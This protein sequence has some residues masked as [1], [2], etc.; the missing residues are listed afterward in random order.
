MTKAEF[1]AATLKNPIKTFLVFPGPVAH[2]GER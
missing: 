2:F 1:A